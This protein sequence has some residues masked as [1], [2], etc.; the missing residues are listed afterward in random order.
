MQDQRQLCKCLIC[1]QLL[2]ERGRGCQIF[3]H[4]RRAG[5]PPRALQ[6]LST[7]DTTASS[8]SRGAGVN[9]LDGG[10]DSAAARD[11]GRKRRVVRRR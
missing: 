9:P 10:E 4:L 2:D 8:P 1:K 5:R 6:A 7:L 3:R 11:F